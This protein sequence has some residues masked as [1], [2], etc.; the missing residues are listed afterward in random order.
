[1]TMPVRNVYGQYFLPDT[2]ERI[3]KTQQG[4]GSDV[5]RDM[6]MRKREVWE[7]R[8]HPGNPHHWLAEEF[9][10]FLL[11]HNYPA[12]TIK[13]R[14]RGHA[15]CIREALVRGRPVP[16]LV[17]QSQEGREALE[18]AMMEV[19]AHDEGAFHVA[20]DRYV[21]ELFATSLAARR[22]CVPFAD[23]DPLAEVFLK[24]VGLC[25]QN[26]VSVSPDFTVDWHEH[27]LRVSQAEN[28]K[29]FHVQDARWAATAFG[30]HLQRI[31][32][33]D[34]EIWVSK[35]MSQGQ[36]KFDDMLWLVRDRTVDLSPCNQYQRFR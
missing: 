15:L 7:T 9:H 28:G 24:A 6:G 25:A 35:A 12:N 29:S 33:S 26:Q 16:Q 21:H 5:P 27:P 8:P 11:E 20:Q 2:Q 10:A 32:R 34:A 1:M 30:G 3:A 36:L 13:D 19:G 14:M 18:D 17:M 4:N 23:R 22:A 31:E